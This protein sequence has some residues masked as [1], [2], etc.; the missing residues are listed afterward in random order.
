MMLDDDIVFGQD[1][2]TGG[3][4]TVSLGDLRETSVHVVG[5]AGYGK[6]Y[7]LRWVIDQLIEHDQSFGVI[8]PHGELADFA[9]EALTRSPARPRDVIVIDPTDRH[10]A[11]GFNPLYSG[12]ADVAE[13][14]GLVMDAFLKGWGAQSFDETPRL[15][16]LLR[17]T[18]RTL[19]EN[20]L[21]LLEGY[22]L[23]DP[24]EAVFRQLL[25]EKVSDPFVIDDWRQFEK[26]PRFDKA[27][28][29]ESTRNRLRRFLHSD[30]LHLMFSQT[31]RTLKFPQ[32]FDSGQ[33]LLANLGGLRSRESRR[34]L[35][36]L[37]ANGIFAG[38]KSRDSR[39]RRDY[40]VIIDEAGEFV[41]RDLAATLDQ[42]RKF[43]VHLILAHQ[44]LRQLEVEDAEVLSS[45]MCNAKIKVVFGGLERR[46]VECLAKE[47]F[48]GEVTGTRV[49]HRA[50]QTKFRPIDDKFE[51]TTESFSETENDSAS[52]A[53]SDSWGTSE[54]E[55][56]S[57]GIAFDGDPATYRSDDEFRWSASCGTSLTTSSSRSI[58]QSRSRQQGRSSGGSTSIVPITR[59]EEFQE[60][61][62]R[63]FFSVEE[64][65]EQRIAALHQLPKR[66]AFLKV[67]NQPV[68][69]IRTPDV[70]P[71]RLDRAT[72]RFGERARRE[73]PYVTP[74]E[75]VRT[76]ITAR[77]KRIE[78][79]VG[80]STDARFPEEARTFRE[81]ENPI[82]IPRFSRHR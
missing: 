43:G 38:G 6:S 17:A 44:R 74:V 67:Y 23:L 30:Q 20:R 62:G 47:L 42:L 45:V 49:K 14:V 57:Q 29:V 72:A 26:L 39:H 81:P 54:T 27:S 19:I 37:L 78:V 10:H 63:Q 69:R 48:T 55:S 64:E 24:D 8:D 65:W 73:S 18:I 3:D 1:P 33:Y 58:S 22:R 41:T 59:H 68:Q 21:T 56:S 77:A 82:S 32:I 31:H 36:A 7:W 40:F 60:E 16:G 70:E 53:F 34:L 76:E 9:L 50:I 71:E 25:V 80:Q 35:G 5:A 66:E 2:A 75:T 13:Q 28:L 11:V 79:L 4:V 51:V 46:E 61:T 12:A 15:E 52:D